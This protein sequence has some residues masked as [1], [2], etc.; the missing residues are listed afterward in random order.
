MF[1]CR[2]WRW[3]TS[4]PWRRRARTEVGSGPKQGELLPV[5]GQLHQNGFLRRRVRAA[6]LR[7]LHKTQLH[8]F[9]GIR[10]PGLLPVFEPAHVG[11]E[12]KGPPP[13][14]IVFLA[15]L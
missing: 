1:W 11:F 7:D 3:A 13:N 2:R 8:D 9:G 12:V 5:V 15:Q 10:K 14:G 4:T 6:G